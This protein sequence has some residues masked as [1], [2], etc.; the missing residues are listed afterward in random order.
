[1]GV[2]IVSLTSLG[3]RSK[4]SRSNASNIESSMCLYLYHGGKRSFIPL[5]IIRR[6]GL[7]TRN[8]IYLLGSTLNRRFFTATGEYLRLL[9]PHSR[10][11]SFLSKYRGKS[12]T[13][14]VDL[15]SENRYYT[16]R[17]VSA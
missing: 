7:S 9:G 1:M 12:V 16:T 11:H 4:E 8:T 10:S 14:L 6:G 17:I 3:T 15:S 5:W 13:F 2:P